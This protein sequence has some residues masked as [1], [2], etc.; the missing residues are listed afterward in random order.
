VR[1]SKAT[2]LILLNRGELLTLGSAT[3]VV[4]VTGYFRGGK[5]PV[6]YSIVVPTETDALA[7]S[8]HAETGAI[9]KAVVDPATGQLTITAKTPRVVIAPVAKYEMGETVT[10]KATDADKIAAETVM[11]TIKANRAPTAAT[12]I[13]DENA[14]TVGTQNAKDALRDGRHNTTAAVLATQPNPVCA[15]FASCVFT[16]KLQDGTASSATLTRY[17]EAATADDI[18]G[19][20]ATNVIMDDDTA[21]M[22]FSIVDYDATKV[23]ASASGN[24]IMIGG[25]KSTW[26]G[27]P[28]NDHEPTTVTIM[29]TD[30]N[31]LTVEHEIPVTVDSAP[32]LSTKFLFES[33]YELTAG[34]MRQIIVDVGEHFVDPDNGTTA[35]V[36]SVTSSNHAVALPP[37]TTTEALTM[38]LGQGT[39]TVTITA[40]DQ[41][42]QTAKAEF[43]VNVKAVVPTT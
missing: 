36:Y 17:T 23:L 29:A 15:T 33:R 14:L 26:V 38:R 35:L 40:T 22:T 32:T 13:T 25:V 6:T 12:V 3:A 39:A 31:D 37:A 43:V 4:D 7:A 24:K 30:A 10:I 34:P 21:G 19:L 41:R 5:Q 1:T 20:T 27:A 2:E 9:F 8:V 42:G 11:L 16:I 18:T 28:T